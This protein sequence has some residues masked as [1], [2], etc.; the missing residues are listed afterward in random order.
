[1]NKIILAAVLAA[2]FF[3]T[4]A[5]FAG[6]YQAS[7]VVGGHAQGFGAIE[8]FSLPKYSGPGAIT[9]VNIALS[10]NAQGLVFSRTL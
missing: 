8:E 7:T 2:R 4:S 9:G 5:S 6:V 3:T 10:G 1:M